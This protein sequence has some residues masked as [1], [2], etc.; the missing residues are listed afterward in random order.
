[1]DFYASAMAE[2]GYPLRVDILL[3]YDL[4]QLLDVHDEE[5]NFQGYRFENPEDKQGAL[6]G[7]ISILSD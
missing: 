6:L 4:D 1:M 5:G 2:R 3:A 7:V